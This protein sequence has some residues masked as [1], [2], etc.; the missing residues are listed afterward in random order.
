M[1]RAARG[2]RPPARAVVTRP[3]P[4]GRRAPARRERRRHRDGVGRRAGPRRA[5]I[6]TPDPSREVDRYLAALLVGEDAALD[7]A[8]A[9]NA[10]AGLPAI[11][12]S[13]SQ[14]KL[15]QLI[16]EIH[17]ARTILE[18]G[19]LGGYSTIWLAR[20]LPPEGRLTTLELDP[21]YAEVAKANIARAGLAERVEV[22]VGPALETL[23]QLTAEGA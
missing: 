21:R 23:A 16:A 17:G 10:A 20:A 2:R 4:D 19:T 14:G 9:A 11:D 7:A 6:V 22:R 18:L 12:V 3:G 13:P 15:L 8:L 5:R 1:V